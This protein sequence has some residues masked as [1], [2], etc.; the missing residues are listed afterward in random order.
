MGKNIMKPIITI[1]DNVHCRANKYAREIILPFLSYKSAVYKPG[2]WVQ[3]TSF[4]GKKT[5]R[6]KAY[7]GVEEKTSYLITGRKG[8]SGLFYTGLLPRIKKACENKNIKI[9]IKGV[10][11]KIKPKYKE[12]KLEG[13]TFRK[14]QLKTIRKM[15]IKQRGRVVAP[16]GSGKTILA[17]GF[18]SMFQQLRI[19]FLCH[20]KDLLVQTCEELEK[21]GFD[22]FQLGGGKKISWTS[23]D[24]YNSIVL[25]ST[26][27]SFSKAPN[28]YKMTYFDAVIVDEGH[29][30]SKENSQYGKL[31]SGNLAPIRIS[32]TATVPTKEHEII[33]N[34]G[35][36]GPTIAE[37]TVEDGIKIGIIAKPKVNLICVPYSIN[38]DKKCGNKY[39]GYYQYG[40]V[41]NEYRNRL[42]VSL[43]I[44]S[45]KKNE[46]V[47]IIVD[48]IE[49]GE[50]LKKM[51]KSNKVH[52]SF[53]KGDMDRVAR[54]SIK[55]EMKSEKKMVAICTKVWK[56]GINIP[57][58]RHVIYAAGMKEEKGIKQAMGRG[59][60]V[61]KNKNE[62]KLTDFMDPYKYIAEHSVLRYG[63]YQKLGWLK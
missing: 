22:Y 56:E 29:H 24:G 48:K 8:T 28:H 33:V 59:L 38:T 3:E 61:T 1:L 55:K 45:I 18:M 15:A 43:V 51:L 44:D 2:R 32:L 25:V 50:T 10:Q 41:K 17:L 5:K 30:A 53:V 39:A 20:T 42:I 14:D 52:A 4:K 12:P 40:I 26:I 49:H 34:E 60:R 13:I 37:L 46:V 57:A 6:V 11:D 23:L 16:T 7:G 19:L 54:Q 36:F 47:L 63:I 62:I 27:Q 58:L 21:F 31:M 35:L 9:E